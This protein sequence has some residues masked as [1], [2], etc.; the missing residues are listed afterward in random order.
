MVRMKGLRKYISKH[1]R[2]F[3]EELAYNVAG[4]KYNAL[5]VEKAAQRKVYYN[6]TGST[7]GDMVYLTN[8]CWFQPYD[9]C[10]KK[11]TCIDFTLKVVGDYGFHGGKVFDMWL[12]SIPLHSNGFDFTP[13]L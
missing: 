11:N 7:L 5:E 6:V 4:R 3:T 13:Y 10:K 8:T 9:D 12:E 2:H 1:G